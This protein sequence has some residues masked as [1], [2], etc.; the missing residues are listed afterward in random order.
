MKDLPKRGKMLIITFLY[1]LYAG[2]PVKLY[3]IHFCSTSAYLILSVCSSLKKLGYRYLQKFQNPCGF[4]LRMEAI[5]S[6]RLFA[7][8][9]AICFNKSCAMILFFIPHPLSFLLCHFLRSA[10]LDSS[11]CLGLYSLQCLKSCWKSQSVFH[12][13]CLSQYHSRLQSLL[14]LESTAPQQCFWILHCKP[15]LA[16]L[17]C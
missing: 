7:F 8:S 5:N 17:H 2:S 15:G 1:F 16:I 9:L 13:T 3:I 11:S 14:L 6:S 10:I 12:L 4:S